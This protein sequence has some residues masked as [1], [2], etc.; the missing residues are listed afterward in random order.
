MFETRLKCKPWLN[1]L[2]KPLLFKGGG[3]RVPWVQIMEN[4]FERLGDGRGLGG[5][6]SEEFVKKYYS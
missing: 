1:S 4:G 5:Y 3:V 2:T 6:F